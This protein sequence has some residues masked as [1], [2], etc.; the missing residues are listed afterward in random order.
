[1][2][3]DKKIFP[4][5]LILIV[6]VIVTVGISLFLSQKKTRSGIDTSS[7][8]NTLAYL[9]E[10]YDFIK[11]G[12]EGWKDAGVEDTDTLV[13][14]PSIKGPPPAF[15]ASGDKIV[16]V[17]Y[18]GSYKPMTPKEFIEYV[19]SVRKELNK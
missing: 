9:E 5:I 12:S 8:A 19:E 10:K 4:R 18:P 16:C 3:K 13:E 17:N 11:K 1:M 15:R 2:L 6:G 14:E 7:P